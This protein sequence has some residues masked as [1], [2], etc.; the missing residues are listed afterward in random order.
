[1]K[2][3]NNLIAIAV[4]LITAAVLTTPAPAARN[5]QISVPDFTKGAKIPAGATH[6]WNL[7][8]TGARGWIFSDQMVTTDARQIAITKVDKGSPADGILAVGDVILCVGGKLTITRWRAD[9]TEDVLVKLSVLGNYSATAPHECPKSKRILEQGCKALSEKLASPS[10]GRQDP[11]TRSLN[12]LALLA[13]GD[14]TYLPLIKKEAQWAANYSADAM[15]TWYYGYVMI[16]LSEYVMATGDESVMPGLRRLALDA[17]KSQSAVGSWGHKFA[18][19]DGRLGG[20]GMMNSPGVPLTISL[21][22]ARAAGVKDPA[23][24]H[25][26]ELSARL[27]RF[28]IGKGAVPYGDHHPWIQNHDDNGKCGMAAVLFNLLDE[29]K[30][31]EFFSRMSIASHGPERDTG[32]TGN[33]F[34]ILWAMPGVAQSGP[35]AT[36]AWMQ[37]FGTWY[38]DLAR[39]WDGSFP[40]QGPPEAANDSYAGWDASGA[41][42]LAYA[43]PLKKLYLTGKRPGVVP[44]LSAAAAQAIILDGR[45]WSNKDRNSAYDKLT[46]DQL[47]ACLGSWS[48]IVRERAAMALARRRDIPVQPVLKMLESPQIESRYGACQALSALGGRGAPAVA[49][50]RKLLAEPDLWLRIKAADALA[51]IGTPAIQAVPELLELLAKVDTKNDPRGMQQRYFSFALFDNGGEHAVGMLNRSLDGVDR[52]L[53][54]QAVRAGLK[55]QDGRARGAIGSVYRNLSAEDIKPLLPAILQAVVQPAPSGEMFADE[56]RLEGL[57]I[58]AKHRIKEGISACVNYTRDQNPWDSQDRTPKLME[59]LLSYGA[60]TKSVIPDL[61]RIADYFEKD[62]K[63]FPRHLMIMKAKCV[64]ETIR[65]IH[66]STDKPELIGIQ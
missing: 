25:A 4:S 46:G 36:G 61:T 33:F 62:E 51:S 44:Q 12:A 6:D 57:R 38:F 37:E 28:Y 8:A 39:C 65:A 15:Q 59:I 50:L 2:T 31:A 26:I 17:A 20:Y 47:F 22:M 11:I 52:E 21:V 43:M 56:I 10:Y 5:G 35:H 63:D 18:L 32:H 40:H 29:A 42:L 64:R 9:K 34:N 23:L 13:S 16:W 1:M 58:L 3:N 53:L 48:P 14:P 24:D 49:A 41:Y 54:Y 55:N 66:A 7:G 45:G 19:P 60:N 30:G 27:L